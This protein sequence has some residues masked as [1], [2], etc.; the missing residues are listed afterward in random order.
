M[1]Y[2]YIKE[3]DID[4]WCFFLQDNIMI[5]DVIDEFQLVSFIVMDLLKYDEQ[6]KIVQLVV[7]L[8]NFV[9]MEL[10]ICSCVIVIF[11]LFFIGEEFN[12]VEKVFIELMMQMFVM[13][14]DFFF[15]ECSKF[16]YWFDVN[17]FGLKLG[18]VVDWDEVCFEFLDCFVIFCEMFEC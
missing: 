10:F 9:E 6:C 8:C 3:I 18:F 13:L 11:D 4:Y 14:F 7:G 2:V 17:M 1:W 15:E 5:V 16:I 12:W